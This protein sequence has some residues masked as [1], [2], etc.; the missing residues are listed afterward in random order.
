MRGRHYTT[1]PRHVEVMEHT[2]RDSLAHMADWVGD[3]RLRGMVE[4][5]VAFIAIADGKPPGPDAGP[6]GRLHIGPGADALITH[7]GHL[8]FHPDPKGGPG[9]L[10][11]VDD[12]R[13]YREYEP[14]R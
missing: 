8:V 10:E 4:P 5:K 6:V 2:G 14:F 13:F 11:V 3:L 7:G 12:E 1:V 9:R